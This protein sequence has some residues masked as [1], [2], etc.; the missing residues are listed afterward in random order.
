M[1]TT[2]A[3]LAAFLPVAVTLVLVP[4]V[5]NLV[6]LRETVARGVAGGLAAVAG[7]S[8][9]ILAWSTAVAT[10][11]GALAAAHPTA[12]AG[13]R[14]AGAAVLVVG[15][16][17]GLVRLRRRADHP[18]AVQVSSTARQRTPGGG[19]ATR[20][21]H[22]AERSTTMT[23][24]TSFR[25][26]AVTSLANPRCPVTAVSVLPQFVVPGPTAVVTVLALG[27]LWT[28]LAGVWNLACIALVHR[29][30]AL[31]ARPTARRVVDGVSAASLVAVGLSVA[32]TVHA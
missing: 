7:T 17:H 24:S 22:R 31:L 10:G 19:A 25:A 20:F 32:A 13:L 1:T 5:N 4:G 30:R 21:G 26:A 8:V 27:V 14:A 28:T 23:A 2:T 16:L 6:V 3:A 18:V 11:L 12:F 29:G 15:G 9:G